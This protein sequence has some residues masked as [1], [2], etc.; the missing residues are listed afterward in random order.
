MGDG[1]IRR[2]AGAGGQRGQAGLSVKLAFERGA[3]ALVAALATTVLALAI[4][5][6]PS[7]STEAPRGV[8]QG[9]ALGGLAKAGAVLLRS[10]RAAC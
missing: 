4:L 5:Y 7:S 9:S 2:R 8:D 10:V 3:L 1:S 6:P